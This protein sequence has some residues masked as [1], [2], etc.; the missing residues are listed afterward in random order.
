M[1]VFA[2]HSARVSVT[3][4]WKLLILNH[5]W[6]RERLDSD[7]HRS[8][9]CLHVAEMLAAQ[10]VKQGLSSEHIMMVGWVAKTPNVIHL[11]P[12]NLS[13]LGCPGCKE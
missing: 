1:F 12:N 13:V 6:L 3:C 4:V 2:R 9:V 7:F 11:H 5:I 8:K 10:R